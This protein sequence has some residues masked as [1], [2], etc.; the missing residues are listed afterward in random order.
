MKTCYLPQCF[1][2]DDGNN[3]ELWNSLT[4][5]CSLDRSAAF[6]SPV[7]V[8]HLCNFSFYISF[9]I[10]ILSFSLQLSNNT[11]GGVFSFSLPSTISPA[12]SGDSPP[13]LQKNNTHNYQT[14][15]RTIVKA[16]QTDKPCST[17]K[18][19]LHSQGT[20]KKH[21]ITG[22]RQQHQRRRSDH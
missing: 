21:Y 12:L 1:G 17:W 13:M 2:S 9:F 19:K 10:L 16:H 14:Q 3:C 11:E 18:P 8:F 22:M 7:S 6:S 5:F 15:K 20:R 4:C